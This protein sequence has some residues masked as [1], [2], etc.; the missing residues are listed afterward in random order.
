MEMEIGAVG[1]LAN[2]LGLKV[3]SVNNQ[4]QLLICFSVEKNES[5]KIKKTY[6]NKD[7][8]SFYLLMFNQWM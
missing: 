5:Y 1:A 2:K 7:T 6:E 3:V 8:N 4:G